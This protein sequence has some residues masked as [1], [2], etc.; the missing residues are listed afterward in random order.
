MPF[1]CSDVPDKTATVPP[2]HVER[3]RDISS[4]TMRPSRLQ[5]LPLDAATGRSSGG[6]AK[7]HTASH[8]WTRMQNY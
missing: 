3:S 6:L 5:R 1:S 7:F 4:R 2:C 8:P